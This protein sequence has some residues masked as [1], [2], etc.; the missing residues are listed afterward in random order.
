MNRAELARAGFEAFNRGDVDAVLELLS[1]D[2]EVHSTAETGEE[3]TYHG[4]DGYLAWTSIW[5]DA[6]RDFRIELAEVEEVD[7]HNLLVISRQKGEGKGSGLEVTQTVVYLFTID[8]A[9]LIT[10]L[11][12]YPTREAALAAAARS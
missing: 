11:H 12:L 1:P 7:Q 8:D 4:R 3:G 2:V 10:R 6:W 5:L 9:G